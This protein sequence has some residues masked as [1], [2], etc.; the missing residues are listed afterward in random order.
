MAESHAVADGPEMKGQVVLITGAASGIGAAAAQRFARDGWTVILGD[1]AAQRLRSV[2]EALRATGARVHGIVVDVCDQAS[3][4]AMVETAV[5]ACGGFDAVCVNAGIGFPERPFEQTADDVDP[6]IDVNLKGAIRVLI[7]VLSHVRR[8]GAIVIT[9]S[10]SGLMAHE[11][12]AVYAATKLALIG[13]GRSLALE[14]AE[15]QIRVNMVCPGAVDT[16]MIRNVWGG[17]AEARDALAEYAADNP[18][19][20]FATADDVAQAIAF[21]SGPA[22]RHITGVSLRIDGGDGLRGAL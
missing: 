22:A 6:L 13:L 5:A 7:A 3:I 18:L 12:G 11:G 14:L 4:G 15:R 2:E 8:G 10:T 16:P 1:V 19:R 20:A 17:E 9:S 21:L